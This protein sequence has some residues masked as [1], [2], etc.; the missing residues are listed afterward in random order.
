MPDKFKTVWFLYEGKFYEEINTEGRFTNIAFRTKK[1]LKHFLT[2][3]GFAYD[4]EKD[5]YM[6]YSQKLWAKVKEGSFF[7][8]PSY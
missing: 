8:E 7:D 2:K 1:N 6:N 3:R 5:V 4:P